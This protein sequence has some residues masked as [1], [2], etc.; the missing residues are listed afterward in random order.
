MNRFSLLP[1]VYIAL[2]AMVAPSQAQP[3]KKQ[4]NRPV[5]GGVVS[6][7]KPSNPF[8][9]GAGKV[10]G[11]VVSAPKP[12]NT[13]GSGI[14]GVVG[15]VVSAPNPPLT[16]GQV[17]GGVIG[18]QQVPGLPQPVSQGDERWVLTVSQVEVL[19]Q[20]A[21]TT[22][23]EINFAALSGVAETDYST[24]TL[25]LKPLAGYRLVALT[26]EARNLQK[27]S[28]SLSWIPQEVQCSLSDTLSDLHPLLLADSPTQGGKSKLVAPDGR[29][30]FTLIFSIPTAVAP[31]VLNYTLVNFGIGERPETVVHLLLNGK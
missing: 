20:Y 19:A 3:P 14:G 9:S 4:K 27:S 10:V 17:I 11:G 7:P 29:L 28:V 15:G 18:S 30:H 26:M 13:I 6:S 2:F 5:V 21:P 31:Q 22:K 23:G 24:G 25:R 16:P 1:L 8:G 12:P